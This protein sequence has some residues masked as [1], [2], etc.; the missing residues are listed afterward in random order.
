M[1]NNSCTSPSM[2]ASPWRHI[3]QSGRTSL[4]SY[5]LPSPHSF[6]NIPTPAHRYPQLPWFQ[7]GVGDHCDGKSITWQGSDRGDSVCFGRGGNPPGAFNPWPGAAADGEYSGELSTG[8]DW[9]TNQP[10]NQPRWE[11]PV[12]SLT[13]TRHPLAL[14]QI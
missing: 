12:T 5:V 2:W 10:T 3:P 11:R 9:S 6:T 4:Y 13:A 8:P 7:C 14:E 1:Q